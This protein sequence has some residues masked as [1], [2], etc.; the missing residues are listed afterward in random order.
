MSTPWI[1]SERPRNRAGSTIGAST[2]S[3]G[4][5]HATSAAAA[6]RA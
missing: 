4:L 3:A 1:G 6:T 5:A 2:S